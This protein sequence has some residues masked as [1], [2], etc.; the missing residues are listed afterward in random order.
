MQRSTLCRSR[1]ELSNAYFLAKF[2]FDAAEN[3]PCQVCP[4]PR[5]A[6]AS[7]G[8]DL[9]AAGQDRPRRRRAAADADLL[10]RVD[11]TGPNVF[12]RLR[13]EV[14]EHHVPGKYRIS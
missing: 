8:E 11:G 5:N 10:R 7:A 12:E 14:E 6:T 1:R 2:S 9:L 13:V 4:L 3:E